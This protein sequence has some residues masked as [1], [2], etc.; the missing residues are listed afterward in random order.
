MVPIGLERDRSVGAQVERAVDVRERLDAADAAGAAV[1]LVDRRIARPAVGQAI[2]GRIRVEDRL[3]FRARLQRDRVV[4]VVSQIVVA[5]C[6]AQARAVVEPLQQAHVGVIP[7]AAARL[8]A[9]PGAH[10]RM[11]HVHVAREPAGK[12]AGIDAR[13]LML[14]AV[15]AGGKLGLQRMGG[16]RIARDEVDEAAERLIGRRADVAGRL[17]DVDAIE[18]RGIEKAHRQGTAVGQ[19][20]AVGDPVDRQTDLLLVEAAHRQPH[21]ETAG[22]VVTG[23]DLQA[24]YS[25]QQFQRIEPGRLFQDLAAVDDRIGPRL[26][27]ADGLG[28]DVDRL[29]VGGRRRRRVC[30]YGLRGGM[31]RE[32][33]DDQGR[34][35]GRLAK[36]IHDVWQ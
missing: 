35:E 6:A 15:V 24:R 2:G 32:A 4:V 13:E 17:R 9:R 34:H 33:G 25:G 27:L 8:V 16:F 30:R 12:F 5:E 20:R 21:R 22:G 14:E 19:R 7:H 10:L 31:T 1:V 23:A 18:V 28:D 3:E 36:R 11:R 29:N 26:A